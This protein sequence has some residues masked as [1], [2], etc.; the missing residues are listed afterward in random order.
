MWIIEA[1]WTFAS[2]IEGRTPAALPKSRPHGTEV[3]IPISTFVL[4]S[5]GLLTEPYV[6]ATPVYLTCHKSNLAVCW[7]LYGTR[8]YSVWRAQ[9]CS[10]TKG[11]CL[12]CFMTAHPLKQHVK[13]HKTL[14][15]LIINSRQL[16]RT[17]ISNTSTMHVLN[18]STYD[19]QLNL[20]D[21]VITTQRDT[22]VSVWCIDIIFTWTF[23]CELNE[24]RQ[25][26]E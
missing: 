14:R 2:V 19:I 11:N 24:F 1:R 23:F 5:T 21:F 7:V 18:M 12:T 4:R 16:K 3:T 26:C 17:L 6:Y 9:E 13:Q 22:Y 25:R 15:C 8:I 10:S 20:S